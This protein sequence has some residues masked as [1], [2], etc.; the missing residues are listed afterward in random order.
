MEHSTTG[1]FLGGQSFAWQPILASTMS[2]FRRAP[3]NRHLK[4]SSFAFHIILD[5]TYMPIPYLSSRHSPAVPEMFSWR[6]APHPRSNINHG[7]LWQETEP[8]WVF[9]RLVVSTT[10]AGQSELVQEWASLVEPRLGEGKGK[11]LHPP[12]SQSKKRSRAGRH[13]L[14]GISKYIFTLLSNS[15]CLS[16]LKFV[17]ERAS[18]CR[19]GCRGE[20]FLWTPWV[21]VRG[22]LWIWQLVINYHHPSDPST[23]NTVLHP[24]EDRFLSNSVNGWIAKIAL[25]CIGPS[26]M[27]T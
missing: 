17:R 24:F 20:A 19:E 11:E 6:G 14:G 4:Y 16:P 26:E 1:V 12:P 18:S 3:A 13:S 9:R 7:N 8:S 25:H 5:N 15:V 2:H 22:A 23:Y 27:E 10:V 21:P